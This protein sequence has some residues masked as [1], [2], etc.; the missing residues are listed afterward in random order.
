MQLDLE[1]YQDLPK[2]RL[3]LHLDFSRASR[4]GLSS[5]VYS[6]RST[7]VSLVVEHTSFQMLRCGFSLER[8][9]LLYLRHYPLPYSVSLPVVSNS[10]YSGF[11]RI[12]EVLPQSITRHY[13]RR[14]CFRRTKCVTNLI[15]TQILLHVTMEVQTISSSRFLESLPFRT[16]WFYISPAR[17]LLPVQYTGFPSR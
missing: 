9:F 4:F 13:A 3:Y 17:S 1:M 15:A 12:R 2:F 16:A 8:I 14:S 7:L 5:Y 6:Q 11:S 10:S